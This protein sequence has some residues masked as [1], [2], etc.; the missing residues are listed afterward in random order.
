MSINPD[1]DGIGPLGQQA[2]GAQAEVAA[3]VA[4]ATPPMP[5]P[6]LNI[7]PAF[8]PPAAPQA[9]PWEAQVVAVPARARKR[10]GWIV[11]A[12]I[13]AVGLIA[14]GTLGYFL[15][16]TTVQ[17]E[18]AR[19]Q[20]AAAQATL[21]DT[22]GQLAARKATDAY[23]EMYESNSGRVMTE[24]ENVVA[25]NSY[26]TCR[27]AAQDLLTD[28][29]A[30]QAARSGLAVPSALASADSEVGDAL[31]AAIA[32]DQELISGMDTNDDA[33]IKDG[34]A[35]LPAAMLSFA[36]A[37]VVLAGNFS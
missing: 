1:V 16:T 18:A 6:F 2:N 15:Y 22:Q 24:Y 35:K 5:L 4:V 17:R 19:H 13:A 32:A 7:A 37:E 23:L 9:P 11:P 10:R 12:A 36:K 27:A 21:K 31:S 30:F 25:C 20:L 33:K 29:R 8:E 28:L 34:F 3:P 26:A 14:S